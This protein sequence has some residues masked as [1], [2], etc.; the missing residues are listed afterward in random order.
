MDVI[1]E[2][3]NNEPFDIIT[4]VEFDDQS[5]DALAETYRNVAKAMTRQLQNRGKEV[6]SVNA[7]QEILS[8]MALFGNHW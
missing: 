7:H 1:D 5:A 6:N 4:E 8:D 3:T 2:S